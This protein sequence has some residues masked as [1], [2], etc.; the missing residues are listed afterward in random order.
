M[1]DVEDVL[2]ASRHI[3]YIPCPT[4]NSFL[5][6]STQV[7]STENKLLIGTKDKYQGQQL[8]FCYAGLPFL[9]FVLLVI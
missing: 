9:L 1:Q 4:A 5:I 3:H 7:S 2:G 6:E 8:P